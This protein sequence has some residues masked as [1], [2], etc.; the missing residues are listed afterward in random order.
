MTTRLMQYHCAP[1]QTFE[2]EQQVS[3]LVE[4]PGAESVADSAEI[5]YTVSVAEVQADGTASLQI[6]AVVKK[7]FDVCVALQD[8]STLCRLN[9][10]GEMLSAD[11]RPPVIPFIVFPEA[12]VALK[13]SWKSIEAS[14][15]TKLEME[16]TVTAVEAVGDDVYAHVVSE[17]KADG[18][19]ALEFYAVRVFSVS[20]GHMVLGRSVMKSVT[21]EGVTSTVVVE[22]KMRGV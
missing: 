12:S 7:Q 13:E 2:F 17:G 10:R 19:P 4:K 16:H 22:E 14:G 20:G 11:P 18:P 15:H 21:A 6:H 1:G 3:L 5:G 8:E 9:A